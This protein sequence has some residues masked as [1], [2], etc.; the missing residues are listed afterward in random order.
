MQGME[1]M[2]LLHEPGKFSGAF[3]WG[4]AHKPLCF[5]PA[6]TGHVSKWGKQLLF[7]SGFAVK[8]KRW[9]RWPCKGFPKSQHAKKDSEEPGFASTQELQSSLLQPE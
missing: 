6:G 8:S 1:D 9:W 5:L 4:D 3:S 7:A 2:N